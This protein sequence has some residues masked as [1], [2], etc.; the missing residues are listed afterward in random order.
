MRLFWRN[1]RWTSCPKTSKFLK[2]NKSLSQFQRLF[3]WQTKS[4]IL[5]CRSILFSES[6]WNIQSPIFSVSNKT[7]T[8][9]L[10]SKIFPSFKK[11]WTTSTRKTSWSKWRLISLRE[12]TIMNSNFFFTWHLLSKMKK[13]T[14]KPSIIIKNSW[15]MLSPSATRNA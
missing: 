3:S 9:S 6:K 10:D 5:I 4:K 7:Q 13:N 2:K 8:F 12:Q 14:P 15:T 11:F 1:T